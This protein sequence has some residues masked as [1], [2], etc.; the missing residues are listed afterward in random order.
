MEAVG[1]DTPSLR[2][3]RIMLALSVFLSGSCVM[4]LEFLAFRFLQRHFGSSLDVW[5]AVVA[6]CLAALALGY[7]I[8]GVMADRIGTLRALGACLVVGGATGAL[9][10][11][12]AD[13]CGR[14]LMERDIA[15]AWHPHVAAA[16]SSFLPILALGAV[17]PQAIRLYA[18][19]LAALGRVA[20]AV[21]ALSTLGSIV[22]VLATTMFLLQHV[23]V[24]ETLY[25]TSGALVMAGSAMVLLRRR[26]LGAAAVAGLL[27]VPPAASGQVIFENYSAYHHILV[28][29]VKGYR[30]L[31]FD[32]AIQSTMALGDPQRGGFEYTDFFHVP[33]VFNPAARRVLFL[34]LGGGTGPKSFLRLYPG[35]DVEVAEIDPAVVDVA[36]RYFG[37]PESDRLTTVLQDGRVHLQRAKESYDIIVAD[38]YAS[39]PY[40]AYIP[41]H[42]ATIEFFQLAYRRLT[43]GGCIVYNVV[44]ASNGRDVSTLRDLRTTMA[45]VFH[46]TYTFQAASSLNSIVIGVKLDPVE[47]IQGQWPDG[48]WGRHPLSAEELQA[49]VLKVRE[50]GRPTYEGLEKRMTQLS[51]IHGQP[52]RGRTLTD[53]FAPVDLAPGRRR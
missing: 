6:V 7:W 45:R 38:A 46:A 11:V 31:R 43:N 16:T 8:G 44:G 14:Y 33:M 4:I 51:L 42:L 17:L 22:G 19:D 1:M 50:G 32:S 15:V 25:A 18:R 23:G 2:L 13:A 40:G 41:Y 30:L 36:R 3:T 48:P 49:M 35:V 27:L 9:M 52:Y 12:I 26:G 20:G 10:E 39:G 53:N 37:V 24:R 29:D 47:A 34:G 28:E 5:G 21:A